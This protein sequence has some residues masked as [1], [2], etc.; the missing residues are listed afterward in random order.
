MKVKVTP[1][2]RK[3]NID[4]EI[5]ILVNTFR[6][7]QKFILID[8]ICRLSERFSWETSNNRQRLRYLYIKASYFTFCGIKWHFK[9]CFKLRNEDLQAT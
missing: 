7:K 9:K 8:S 5:E 1:I 2:E 4:R 3:Q 6:R